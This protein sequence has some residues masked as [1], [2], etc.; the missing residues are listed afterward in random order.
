[1]PVAE[2]GGNRGDSAAENRARLKERMARIESASPAA[3]K[4]GNPFAFLSKDYANVGVDAAK[5]ANT[6]KKFLIP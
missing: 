6:A 1:M 5:L 3:K 2:G 4:K